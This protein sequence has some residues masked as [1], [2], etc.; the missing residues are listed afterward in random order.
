MSEMSVNDITADYANK[1]F[2]DFCNIFQIVNGKINIT[3]NRAI[4]I[5][6]WFNQNYLFISSVTGVPLKQIKLKS[7]VDLFHIYSLSYAVLL[8]ICKIFDKK[9]PSMY[10]PVVE[11]L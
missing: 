9:V 1:Y 6:N 4:E 3:K 8:H 10:T 11:N 5:Q 2:D 7:K